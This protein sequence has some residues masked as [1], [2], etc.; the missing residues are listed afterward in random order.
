M[1]RTCRPCASATRQRPGPANGWSPSVRRS[2]SRTASPPASSRPNRARWPATAMCRSS[3][4]TWRSTPATPAG[5]CSTC[6]GEVI[7]INSQIYSRSGGYQGV[8]FAIPIDVA[9]NIKEQL[10]KDGKV[11]H[12]RMGVTIQEVSQSLAESFGLKNTAGALVSSVEK[13]SPAAAAGLEARRHHTEAERH[14]R[15]GALPNCHPWSPPSNRAPRSGCTSGARE[16]AAISRCRSVRMRHPGWRLTRG[17]DADKSA[18]RSGAAS[19]EPRGA[20]Q[21]ENPEG[22][23]VE[24]VSGPAARAG[25]R[26]GDIVVSLNGQAIR[27]ISQV[28]SLLDKSGKTLWHC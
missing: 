23:L 15:S 10:L 13:G 5:R 7:G 9:M 17:G 19:A 25:I 18:T 1:R 3:R 2:A 20:R 27:E 21:V 4:P 8:S 12:G 22:L 14:R 24:N 28:R 26:P 6:D 11:S 16:Q